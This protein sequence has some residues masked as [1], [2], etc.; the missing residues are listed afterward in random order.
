M[1]GNNIKLQLAGSFTSVD[2]HNNSH[3][4]YDINSLNP[5]VNYQDKHI[6]KLSKNKQVEWVVSRICDHA[7]GTLEPCKNNRFAQCPLHGWKLDLEKLQYSN[8]NVTKE[9]LAFEVKNNHVV[10]HQPKT[11]LKLPEKIFSSQ[12]TLDLNIR[13]LSHACL[14][15]NCGSINIITDPWILGPC[16]LNGWWHHPPPSSD[17]FEQLLNADLVYIS[18]NHPDHMHEDTLIKLFQHRPDIPIVIPDFK[19]KSAER[20]LRS[21]GFTNILPLAFNQIHKLAG[22]DIYISILKSGDFRDDSGLYLSYGKKQALM[23]VDSSAL[24]H[25]VLPTEIDF[26]A[27]SFAAGASG[28]PWCF[29]HYSEDEKLQIT[30]NRH[31]SVKD[32]IFKYIDVCKPKLYMPY[33]GYFSELA[34]RDK[35]IKKNNIKNSQQTIAYEVAD[36]HPNIITIDPINTD[37]INISKSI[38]SHSSNIERAVMSNKDIN[39]RINGEHVPNEEIFFTHAQEYFSASQFKDELILYLLPCESDFSPLDNGLIINFNKQIDITLARHQDV[40]LDYNLD[41]PSQR[42]LLIKV[43]ATALWQVIQHQKSWE[44]LSIGFH[45]RIHRKPDVYNSDFWY[46]F[47]NIYIK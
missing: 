33:A 38:T 5:G 9:K 29:D 16:F 39:Q 21:R 24:N 42:Q 32:S 43:R 11:H 4:H 27:T 26:L 3:Y 36:L 30:C 46:H 37:K 12:Q 19:T 47:S 15:F 13:F 40:Q 17:A 22:H 41:R 14:L 8:V 23:T 7:S 18:H 44:E 6:V 28:H 34:P 35:Y 20:P 25:Y 10:I 2:D 31:L 1:D 45:C